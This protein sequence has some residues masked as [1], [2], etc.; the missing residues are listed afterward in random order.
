[1]L[2]FNF[3]KVKIQTLLILALRNKIVYTLGTIT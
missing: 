2:Y 1:M 3:Y